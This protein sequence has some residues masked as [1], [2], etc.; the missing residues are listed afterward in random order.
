MYNKLSKK[1]N[2]D[3]KM[4]LISQDYVG[5]NYK[6]IEILKNLD[7]NFKEKIKVSIKLHPNEFH[8]SAFVDYKILVTKYPHFV[9]IFIKAL[10]Y[11]IKFLNQIL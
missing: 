9:E 7:H 8:N 2:K 4:L 1:D 11:T 5:K 6:I 10:M 3:F